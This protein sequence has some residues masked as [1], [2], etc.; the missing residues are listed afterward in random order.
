MRFALVEGKR[1]LPS[2]GLT[3]SCPACGSAVLPKCGSQRVHHWAHRGERVC[4]R[5]WEPE[6]EWHR[7]WK[8]K[9]PLAW[10]EV[11]RVDSSGER[12]IADVH[13]DLGLT[14]EFQYSYLNPKERISRENFYG[15]MVWV[16]SGSRLAGDLPRFIEGKQSFTRMWKGVYVTPAPGKVFPHDWLNCAVPVFFDYENAPGLTEPAMH[17]GRPLW[18]LLPGRAFGLAVV[19]QISREGFIDLVHKRAQSLVPQAFLEKVR[20]AFVMAA[21]AEQAHVAHLRAA[22]IPS[23]RR[24]RWR[25]FRG[26][27]PFPK[28]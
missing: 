5:W 23:Y 24:Q 21:R 16:S 9:F 7:N 25:P 20:K 22:E 15:N 17:I 19:L 3:G 28:F 10:Q 8:D 4:D 1:T 11:I 13:S 12:H 14:I 27:N 26:R 6:T 2:P 18:C